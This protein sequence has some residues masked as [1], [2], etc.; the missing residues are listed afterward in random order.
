VGE[1]NFWLGVGAGAVGI[2]LVLYGAWKLHVASYERGWNGEELKSRGLFGI[3]GWTRSS[4]LVLIQSF[5]EGK[6]DREVKLGLNVQTGRIDS[7]LTQTR[8]IINQLN[9][10]EQ[11]ENKKRPEIS[12]E[13]KKFL[14]DLHTIAKDRLSQPQPNS[15]R[16]KFYVT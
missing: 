9:K 16:R 3:F 4:A 13:E 15:R 14:R 12:A 10:L 11:E 6:H 7:L 5:N 2:S 1:D 8:N